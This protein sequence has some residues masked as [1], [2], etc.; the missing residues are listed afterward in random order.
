MRSPGLGKFETKNFTFMHILSIRKKNSKRLLLLKYI[1]IIDKKINKV[2][3]PRYKPDTLTRRGF[4]VDE[5]KFQASLFRLGY[6]DFHRPDSMNQH[7]QHT[8]T[9]KLIII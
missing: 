9:K 3:L 4:D 5:W 6:L 1:I 7:F 8:E 2:K